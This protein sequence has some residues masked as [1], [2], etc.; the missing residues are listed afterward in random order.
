V[1]VA[2]FYAGLVP[3]SDAVVDNLIASFTYWN[4]TLEEAAAA[5]QLR[6]TAARQGETLAV[7]DTLLA[8]LARSRRATVLSDDPRPYV[9]TGVPVRSVRIAWE[10]GGV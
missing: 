2:E 10:G 4:I 8:A 1:T 7:T 6:Y 5:G 9:V 3:G